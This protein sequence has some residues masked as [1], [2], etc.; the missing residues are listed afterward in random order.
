YAIIGSQASSARSPTHDAV[1]VWGRRPARGTRHE[2]HARMRALP[3]GTVTFLLTD[4]E[5]STNLLQRL[6]D[7][8]ARALGE[9][10]V[11]RAAFAA[12]NGAEVDTQGDAFFVA[13]PTA[14]AAVASAAD[15]TR[16]TAAHRHAPT[17]W[18][19]LR[20]AGRAP[21]RPHRRRWARR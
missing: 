9:H 2:E 1:C 15:A 7:G 14:P 10:R 19:P 4:I 21:R 16:A 8:Y 12:H 18:R 13:F 11:L 5:G 17:G 3:T 6:G 20:R